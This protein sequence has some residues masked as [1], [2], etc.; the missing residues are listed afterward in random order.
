MS[1]PESSD[2]PPIFWGVLIPLMQLKLGEDIQALFQE[3]ELIG[4]IE[5]PHTRERGTGVYLCQ[6]P[7]ASLSELWRERAQSVKAEM[8]IATK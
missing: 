3:I 5:H 1:N 6:K 8:G 4:R 2:R 7:L